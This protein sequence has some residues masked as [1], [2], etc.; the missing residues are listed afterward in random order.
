MNATP[1]LLSRQEQLIEHRFA[2]PMD[3]LLRRLYVDEELT[4]QQIAERLDVH[5]RS[6]IRWMAK[7]HIPTRDRRAL[8]PVEATA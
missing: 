1:V 4:Q 6:V 5:V 8:A 3:V 7:H 2:E